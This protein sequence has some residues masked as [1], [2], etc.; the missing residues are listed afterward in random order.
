MDF[1]IVQKTQKL[2]KLHLSSQRAKKLA[3]DFSKIIDYIN[4]ISNFKDSSFPNYYNHTGMKNISVEDKPN[5]KF[6]LSND[7]AL[8]NAPK[9]YK[10]YFVVPKVLNNTDE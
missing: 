9:K 1:S 4:V 7:E 3:K 8:Q 5:K 10:N 2:A 6:S